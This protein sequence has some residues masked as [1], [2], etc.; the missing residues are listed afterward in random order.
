MHGSVFF[1]WSPLELPRRRLMSAEPPS[2]GEESQRYSLD[3]GA[4]IGGPI[5]R[6]RL[7]FFFGAAPQ[8]NAFYETA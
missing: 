5:L 4:E 8:L 6:D 3:F 1:N 2:A 7:W